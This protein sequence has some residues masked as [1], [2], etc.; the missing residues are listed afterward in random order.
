[1]RHLFQWWLDVENQHGFLFYIDGHVSVYHGKNATLGKKHMSRQKLCL[2]GTCQYWVNDSQGSPYMFVNALVNEKLLEML[3][4]EIVPE[5]CEQVSSRITEQDLQADA[6]MP[7]FTMI[8]DSEGYYPT[9]FRELW[10]KRIAVITTN[11]KMSITTIAIYRFARWCQENYFRYMRQEYDLDRIYQYAVEQLDDII[12]V[13]NPDH[14]KLTYLIKKERGKIS[15]KEP[16]STYSKP[17][18]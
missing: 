14:A 3:S 7:L 6:D 10:Q 1:M 18:T 13:V 8:F 2:P 5:I 4:Q 9:Y 16:H 12:M 17:K 15:R 11:K